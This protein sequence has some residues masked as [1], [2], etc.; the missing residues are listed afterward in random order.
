MSI[1]KKSERRDPLASSQVYQMRTVEVESLA[2]IEEWLYMGIDYLIQEK[3]LKEK[4]TWTYPMTEETFRAIEE[5]TEQ[6]NALERLKELGK[7]YGFD[8]SR[9]AETAQE[10]IQWLYF[11]LPRCR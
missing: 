4:D 11:G 6:I 8:I 3:K 1:T 5:T 10:A 9:P 2:T 7:I